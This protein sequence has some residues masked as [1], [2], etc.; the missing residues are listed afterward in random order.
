M[1]PNPIKFATFLLFGLLWFAAATPAQAQTYHPD[2]KEGLRAFLRQPSDVAGQINAQRLG[3]TL[4]D[5]ANWQTNE[6]WVSKIYN[7]VWNNATPKRL[8]S[9]GNAEN[10]GWFSCNLAG[11]LDAKKWKFIENM[12]FS[13]NRL[14]ALNVEGCKELKNLWCPASSLTALDV[15]TNT[16]LR[17]LHCSLNC[18]TAL[19]VSAN[20]KLTY[21]WCPSNYGPLVALHVG[22][23]TTLKTL[24][25][26]GN[27][28]T[29]LDVSGCTA[30]ETLDCH[31]NQLTHLDAGGCTALKTLNCHS[32][33]LTYLNIS[34]CKALTGLWCGY[35][36]LTALDV[37]GCTALE[38]LACHKNLLTTLNVSGRTTLKE[39]D[40]SWNQLTTL[41]VSGCTKLVDLDC[42][43]NHLLLSDLFVVSEILKKNSGKGLLGSQT[44]QKQSAV[45]GVEVVFV[46]PQNVFNG[47]YTQFA[48]TKEGNT[49]PLSDYSVKNGKI[50]F[51]TEGVYMVTMT[52]TVII[53]SFSWAP[54]CL[55]I[56]YEV[57]MGTGIN[58]ILQT[59]PLNA[60]AANGMLRV[61]GLSEGKEWSVYSVSG[62][63]VYQSIATGN[64]IAIPLN[65][66]GVY[67][68]TSENR[69]VKV[70][71]Y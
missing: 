10:F 71:N 68:V 7:L 31:N 25:C 21:L 22:K 41:D 34:G 23:S 4:A 5:T 47:V 54:T 8:I 19:D 18:F 36:Q 50:T 39:L 17:E 3:L 48:V 56:E 64:E 42:T 2:D 26:D 15:S 33:Q 20:K 37:S 35:N 61:T 66:Q 32:N 44:L 53:S 40:C 46:P 52:N 16:E 45:V 1:N 24:Y 65:A 29:T 13:G 60:W 67:I 27:Q 14:T 69:R 57:K 63:L 28:I 55:I 11:C 59:N 43:D 51:H 30:L 6:G 62:A 9:I 49:A 12:Y 70:V 38:S 58:E